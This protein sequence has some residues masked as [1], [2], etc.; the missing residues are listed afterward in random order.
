MNYFFISQSFAIAKK[1]EENMWVLCVK[2][3]TSDLNF[4]L[5]RIAVRFDTTYAFLDFPFLE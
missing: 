4:K 1:R 3:K 5:D 2:S